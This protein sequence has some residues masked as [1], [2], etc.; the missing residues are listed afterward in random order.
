M[1]NSNSNNNLANN[2]LS[3]V[4]AYLLKVRRML[5]PGLEAFMPNHYFQNPENKM[6]LW[7][8]R[9]FA[10]VQDAMYYYE[11]NNNVRDAWDPMNGHTDDLFEIYMLTKYIRDGR[12]KTPDIKTDDAAFV[13]MHDA[14]TLS[15]LVCYDKT[16]K[17]SEWEEGESTVVVSDDNLSGL[18]PKAPV[19]I[20]YGDNVTYKTI[21]QARR[22]DQFVDFG[23]LSKPEK[24]KDGVPIDTYVKVCSLFPQIFEIFCKLCDDIDASKDYLGDDSMEE[25]RAMGGGGARARHPRRRPASA[26]PAKVKR[27]A[28]PKR[29][30][31]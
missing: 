4:K 17:L 6:T 9:T 28:A 2:K 14:W 25:N 29:K 31:K 20:T 15:R 3:R 21:V 22:M 16:D 30:N 1:S 18:Q 11:G 8:L 27:A 23:N 7:A 12:L 26:K 19:T 10:T 13:L 24:M 5:T